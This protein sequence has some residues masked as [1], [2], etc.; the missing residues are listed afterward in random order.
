MSGPKAEAIVE[1]F[2][3]DGAGV[4]H[5]QRTPLGNH[6]VLVSGMTSAIKSYTQQNSGWYEQLGPDVAIKK[7]MDLEIAS[8]E[9]AARPPA[10]IL[11]IDVGGIRW[12]EPG[13]CPAIQ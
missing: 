12:V 7:F 3:V 9:N 2:F 13:A 4:L 10:S 6:R 11:K 1:T 5:D 8:N